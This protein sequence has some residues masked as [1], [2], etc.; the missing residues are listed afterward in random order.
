MSEAN[1]VMAPLSYN[2]AATGD[3][4][5]N[6]YYC[7]M[8][9]WDDAFLWDSVNWPWNNLTSGS[10]SNFDVSDPVHYFYIVQ[11]VLSVYYTSIYA[12]TDPLTLAVNVPRLLS[13]LWKAVAETFTVVF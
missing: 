9:G 12:F 13:S 7:V 11:A 3:T 1:A 6:G 8:G 2:V 4:I 5:V 10:I